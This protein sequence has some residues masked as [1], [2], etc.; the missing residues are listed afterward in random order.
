MGVSTPSYGNRTVMLVGWHVDAPRRQISLA[1]WFIVPAVI[2]SS[3]ITATPICPTKA[4]TISDEHFVV[5]EYVSVS[6][7][8]K[9][10]TYRVTS[11]ER[12]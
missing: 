10:H 7:R 11:V 6:E 8:G 5:G 2:G 4:A 12:L 3:T 9:M 1:I